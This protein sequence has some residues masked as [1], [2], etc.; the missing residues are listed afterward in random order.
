MSHG[1]FLA[2]LGGSTVQSD[3]VLRGP[4]STGAMT[5]RFPSGGLNMPE[6]VPDSG[7]WLS[8]D[9]NH[10]L[11]PGVIEVKVYPVPPCSTAWKDAA[12]ANATVPLSRRST[13]R[14]AI[15]STIR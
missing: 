13:T 10:P 14:P 3:D 9:N 11:R 4:P 12:A 1:G 7:V 6:P 8:S 2:L 15:G 5:A